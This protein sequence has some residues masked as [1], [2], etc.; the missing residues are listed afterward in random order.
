VHEEEVEPA[1]TVVITSQTLDVSIRVEVLNGTWETFGVDRAVEVDPETVSYEGNEWGP[2]KASFVLRRNPWATWP[3]LSPF[4]PVE[5][6]IGGVVVW[7][8]RTNGTPLKAGAEQ[9]ISVQCEGWQMHLDDDLYKRTYVHASLTDWKDVRSSLEAP[10]A[11]WEASPQVQ[12]ETGVI[13]LSVVSGSVPQGEHVFGVYLDLGQGNTAKVVHAAFTESDFAS[14]YYELHCRSAANIADLLS[15]PYNALWS[16]DPGSMPSSETAVASTAY[17]Y[18]AVFIERLVTATGPLGHDES[19]KIAAVSVFTEEAYESGGAS[20]L[21]SS[22]VIEDALTRATT[23]L[24]EDLSQIDVAADEFDIPSLVL[25]SPKTARE[26][27]EAVNAYHLWVTAI[28]LERRMVFAPPSSE[29][30]LEWGAW[31]SEQIEDASSGE[32]QDI[33]DAVTVEGTQANGE[34]LALTVTAAELGLSTLVGERG[35]TRQKAISLSNA[36]TEAVARKVGEVWLRDQVV[37]PFGG[38][39]TATVGSL[40]TVLGGQPVDP[41]LMVRHVNELLRVSQAVDPTTG[42]VGRDGRI[43]SVAYT[44][45]DRTCQ[46]SMGARTD[47]VEAVIARL[48]VVQEANT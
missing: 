39:I 41:S 24:S 33:Y 12:V 9:Q 23:L 32:G 46:I 19:L 26:V 2:L 47:N 22:T 18:V 6:E 48:A 27:T 15:G 3:D 8:G 40:R 38:A 20:V 17:R 45:A 5:I 4:T 30:L 29:P 44:H 36:T 16:F 21:K 42:G 11:S 14:G 28:D 10:L 34:P 31:G 25:A 37:T 13:T 43:V 1:N 35:F 7:E